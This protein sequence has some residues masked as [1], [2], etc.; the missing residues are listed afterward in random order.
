MTNQTQYGFYVDTSKCTGCKACHVSCKDQ[1]DLPVG[2]NWRR[3]YEY[4]GGT[5][6]VD[7]NTQVYQQ[8]V[9]AY[10]ASIGCNHCS[11]PV[12]VKACPV[13]AMYKR[14]EDGIVRVAEELCIGCESCARACP[15]DAP[16]I[17]KERQIMTKCDGC[18]ERLAEGKKP[19]CVESCPLRALDFDTMENLEAKYGKGDANISALPS[20]SITAP[21]LI[22]K[23]NKHAHRQGEIVNNAEV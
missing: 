10:Y 5:W 17:D 9:F 13:G 21:N 8:D 2:I 16:Q 15:Y 7:P 4:T 14:R 18:Y 3:V 11:N 23:A 20:A 19:I 22:I 12:C 6:T 1:R